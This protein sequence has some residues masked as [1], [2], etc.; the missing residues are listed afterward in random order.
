MSVRYPLRLFF[1][2][3]TAHLS[4]DARAYLD[5]HAAAR[6]EMIA[7]T[8]FGWFIWC[9]G[10]DDGDVPPDLAHVLAHARSL[11]ADYVLFD[12]D[13]EVSEALPS[14]NCST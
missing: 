6:D 9:G 11:D 13:A 10:E 8:P 2:C 14:F 1:D 4:P 5:D 7:S 12:A 3:S